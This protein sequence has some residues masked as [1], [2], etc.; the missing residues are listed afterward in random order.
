MGYGIQ[1]GV[2]HADATPADIAPTLAEICGITLVS[3]DGHVLPDALAKP[4]TSRAARATP[5]PKP[6]P[7]PAP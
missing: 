5:T 1:P 7:A 4:S 2:Y 6:T 3:R